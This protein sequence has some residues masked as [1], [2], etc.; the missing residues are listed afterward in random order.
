MSNLTCKME[1]L[2]R[3]WAKDG[4]SPGAQDSNITAGI[5]K[6]RAG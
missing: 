4:A 2:P 6:M 1:H 5:K 3:K